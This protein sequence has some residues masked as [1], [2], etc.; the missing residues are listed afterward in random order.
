M[1]IRKG[2]PWGTPGPLPV[3]GVV[4]HSDAEARAVILDA[5]RHGRPVPPLGLL[6]GD[7]CLT[8]G[9]RGDTRRLRSSEAMTFPVDLGVALVDGRLQV[10]VA[11]LVAR[12]RW[13]TGAFVAMNAQWLRARGVGL[14]NAAPRGHP[15]DGLLDCY[16]FALPVGD[17]F[18]VRRRA[19]SGSH[20]P[21]PGIRERRTAAAQVRFER[22]RRMVL[23]GVDAGT[24]WDLSVRVEP[25]AITVVV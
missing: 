15:N 6:G 11:H 19:R 4:V 9:G 16:E 12:N 2:E 5:R 8:L 25:D 17:L 20:L 24:A 10:F 7:L 21:H 22:P 13:W 23:D 1:T 14:V 18:Q 3:D